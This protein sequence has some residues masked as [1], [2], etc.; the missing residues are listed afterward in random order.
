MN[1]KAVVLVYLLRI[2]CLDGLVVTCRLKVRISESE[3]ASIA[4][5][6]LLNTRVRDNK[7]GQSIA[8][9][10]SENTA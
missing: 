5:Q 8:E 1:I 4:R 10:R 9:Q 3:R 7:Q 6:R 2:C